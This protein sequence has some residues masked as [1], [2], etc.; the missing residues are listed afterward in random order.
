MIA[1]G[2]AVI[3][4]REFLS[5]LPGCSHLIIDEAH[6]RSIDTDAVLALTKQAM[7]LN[8]RLKVIVMSATLDTQLFSK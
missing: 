8:P 7:I 3:F 4:Y 5:Q 6:E 1:C 2:V